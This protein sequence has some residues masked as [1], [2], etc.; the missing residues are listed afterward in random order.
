[1]AAKFY[2]LAVLSVRLLVQFSLC[3]EK[4]LEGLHSFLE[5]LEENRNALAA[6][7]FCIGSWPPLIYSQVSKNRSRSFCASPVSF[8]VSDGSQERAFCFEG[9]TWGPQ[10]RFSRI[11]SS[12]RYLS[13]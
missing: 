12:S 1:M 4:V 11:N 2:S 6:L 3:R 7:R 9:L 5:A 8:L 10:D 13:L